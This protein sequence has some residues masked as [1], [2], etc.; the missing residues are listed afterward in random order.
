MRR[1]KLEAPSVALAVEHHGSF[2]GEY[3]DV[4]AVPELDLAMVRQWN[5]AEDV[6]AT[7]PLETASG[8]VQR[9]E[10]VR[11]PSTDI[12]VQYNTRFPIDHLLEDE[13]VVVELRQLGRNCPGAVL[14]ARAS[15]IRCG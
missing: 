4:G 12:G 10:S 3:L 5:P 6:D 7:V 15:L 11:I 2:A 1:D 13:D 9:T 8:A 14:V